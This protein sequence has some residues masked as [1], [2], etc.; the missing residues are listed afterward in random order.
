MSVNN[1]ST[2]DEL[3]QQRVIKTTGITNTSHRDYSIIDRVRSINQTNDQY[4][5][6]SKSTIKPTSSRDLKGSFE[7][8]RKDSISWTERGTQ[9]S[10]GGVLGVVKVHRERSRSRV[11][12]ENRDDDGENKGYFTRG[13][14]RSSSRQRTGQRSNSIG[15]ALKG[16]SNSIRRSLSRVRGRESEESRGRSKDRNNTELKAKHKAGP[17]LPPSYKLPP[18]SNPDSDVDDVID[19]LLNE[20]LQ[21]KD[22]LPNT[23]NLSKAETTKNKKKAPSKGLNE[24]DVM[25]LEKG[26]TMMHVSCLLHHST[27][28]IIALLEKEPELARKSN[29]AN[30]TPLHYASMDKSQ[31]SKDVLKKLIMAYPEAVK[32]PNALNSMP[33]HLACLTGAPSTYVVKTFLKMYPKAAMIQSDIKLCFEDDMGDTNHSLMDDDSSVGDE[34]APYSPKKVTAVSGIVNLFASVSNDSKMVET[35]FCPLHLAVI[36]HAS[37]SVIELLVKV[38]PRSI[39]LKTS[40]GRTALDCAQYIVKQHWLYGTDD[41]NAIQNTFGAVEVLENALKQD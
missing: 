33:I 20:K 14:S 16:I 40:R 11:R 19:K 29:H 34:F 15:P 39:H 35:G 37:P 31:M 36:S 25:L 5:E 6:R 9:A 4:L 24:S 3:S 22:K 38:N 8:Q 12:N 2:S 23:S 10:I 17:K 26:N 21:I 28:D 41:E 1:T 7:L 30:E 18:S 32:Q 13:R 27:E